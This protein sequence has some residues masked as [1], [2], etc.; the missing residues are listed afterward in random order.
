M[1]VSLTAGAE[2]FPYPLAITR[3]DFADNAAFD[4]DAFLY[5]NHRFTALDSL[6]ADLS[7][8]SRS[9]NQDLLD[10]V[11]DEYTNFIQLGQL[12]GGC[13]ELVDNI[14]LEVGKF[15]AVLGHTLDDFG[16]S[17][18][19][20][21]AVLLHKRRLSLLKNRIKLI[22]LLHEQCTRFETL[23]ALDAGTLQ[24]AQLAAKLS[25]LATLYLSVTK[26]FA[27]LMQGARAHYASDVAKNGKF[28][29][30]NGKGS[31]LASLASASDEEVC[32]FFDRV[33]KTKV[34]L[35]KYEFKLSL[36]ELMEMARA[37]KA[38]NGDLILQ[39][40]HIYRVTG[41]ANDVVAALKR[42]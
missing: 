39:L 11:N 16:T 27:V 8:L 30:K 14:S 7:A 37:D 13:L 33:V 17:A 41:H 19:A 1:D 38:A 42:K 32:V 10:L 34:S 40:L 5:K 4:P 23:L 3:D 24:S 15:N 20:A 21:D 35:L 22:C 25:T 6:I 31:S 18:A 9:L 12:I 26:T 2:E 28:D 36:D 29:A